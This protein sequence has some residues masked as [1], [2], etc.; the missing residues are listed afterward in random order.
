MLKDAVGVSKIYIACG[1]TDLRLGIDG[2]AFLIQEKF[3]LTPTEKGTLFLFCGR[4]S[5]RI[6]GLYF[7]GDGF[8]LLYKRLAPGFRY[9]WPRTVA[10]AKQLTREQFAELMKGFNPLQSGLI[11][12]IHPKRIG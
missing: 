9:Q 8:L 1:Y 12:E 7:E 5:D 4:K 10:E 6:K 2:L 3:H 11:G